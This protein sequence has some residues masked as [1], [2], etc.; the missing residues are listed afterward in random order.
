M[1]QS[2]SYSCDLLKKKKEEWYDRS[3]IVPVYSTLN[4]EAIT[5]RNHDTCI[6][7]WEW[8]RYLNDKQ[9]DKSLFLFHT[10]CMR[11]YLR[12]FALIILFSYIII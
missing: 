6:N 10:N 9:S 8:I 1:G 2:I 11:G 4:Q 7:E 12:N 3:H 5:I